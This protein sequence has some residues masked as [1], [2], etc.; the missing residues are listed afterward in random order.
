MSESFNSLLRDEFLNDTL[1]RSLANARAKLKAW[2]Q[3]YNGVRPHSSLG[4][5]TPAGVQ[6]PLRKRRP[7]APPRGGAGMFLSRASLRTRLGNS[8][9]RQKD[10]FH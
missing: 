7:E 3:D 2:R 10:S 1:L 8:I 9:G 6:R 5:R 4:Y